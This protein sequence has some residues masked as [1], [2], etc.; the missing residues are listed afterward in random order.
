LPLALSAGLLAARAFW[1]AP[2]GDPLGHALPP[3]VHLSYPTVYIALAP[4]FTLWDGVSMLSMSRLSGFLGGC[5]LLYLVWR[6]WRVV[7]RRMAWT[8]SRPRRAPVRREIGRLL[9]ALAA[10]AAFV[11]VGLLWHRPMAA[12]AGAGSDAVVFDMHSHS[13]ASHDVAGTLMR[14]FDAA[15]NLRW[16]R[17]AGFNAVFL[18]DHNTVAGYAAPV[19]DATRPDDAP[20]LC[21][22]IE[23]SAWKA[24][25][26]LLGDTVEVDQRRYNGSL[27]QLVTLLRTSDS[28]YGALSVLSL[29]E[30][31]RN[32]RDRLDTLLAAGADGLEIVNAS[33]KANEMSRAR[34][35]SVVALAKRAN[36]FVVGASDSHGWGATSMVWNVMTVPGWREESAATGSGSTLCARVL[37][38]LRRG[39]GAS[40]IVERHR[41][42]A[43]SGWPL[44]LTPLG[45][46]WETW[47]SMN[48]T[49]TVVWLAWVWLLWAARRRRYTGA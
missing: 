34:R 40:Q 9:G 2:L 17:R 5:G 26:V 1:A 29:P 14:G 16:H 27:E 36:R 39:F 37:D 48:W 47:R 18:T 13:A 35:D 32:H 33:P 24:H 4:L 42:R 7:V 22:G 31:E 44:W 41:L 49:L 28:V 46:V 10:L 15:A 38:G 3:S 25:V 8:R 30:Y 12:L 11:G 20:G 19:A 23:V 45:V 21:P 43:D 6:L